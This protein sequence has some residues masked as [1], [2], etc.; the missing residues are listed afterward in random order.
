MVM[1]VHPTV[2]AASMIMTMM[3]RRTTLM[4]VMVTVAVILATTAASMVQQQQQQQPSPSQQSVFLNTLYRDARDTRIL[5]GPAEAQVLYERIL[6]EYN[7]TDM[8]TSTRLAAARRNERLLVNA[9]CDTT[10]TASSLQD[11]TEKLQ[12]LKR[13]LQSDSVQYTAAHISV[14]MNNHNNTSPN[15]MPRPWRAPISIVPATAGT[16]TCQEFPFDTT[17]QQFTA[18]QC[19]LSLFLLG[20]CVTIQDAIS[21]CSVHYVNLLKEL[22]LICHCEH[23][24]NVIYALV[25]ITPIDLP[26]VHQTLH[27]VTDWH[28]RVLNRIQMGSNTIGHYTPRNN[29]EVVMYIGPDSLALVEHAILNPVVTTNAGS[30]S[31]PSNL[32]SN[33]NTTT[34]NTALLDLCTGSGVQALAYLMVKMATS[35][36]SPHRAVCVDTNPRALRFCQFSA[37]LNGILP[38]MITLVLGNVVQ[39]IGRVYHHHPH[40]ASPQNDNNNERQQRPLLQLLQSVHPTY[41][42]ITANPPFLP[43]PTDATTHGTVAQRYGLFSSGGPSG[44]VV[45]AAVLSLSKSLANPRGGMTAI[46][47]EFF[48]RGNHLHRGGGIPELIERLQLYYGNVTQN[49][50]ADNNH[51]EGSTAILF[52]NEFPISRQV[53]ANRRADTF[54]EAQ[55]WYD[56]L[57]AENISL[58]SPGLLFVQ[59][60]VPPPHDSALGNTKWMHHHTVPK[61]DLGSIWTPSNHKAI[62]VTR[63][64]TR[65]VFGGE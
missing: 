60:N 56:H 9:C 18:G 2:Y 32:D 19:L 37:A 28:P 12:D 3:M 21:A 54:K 11:G 4:V 5:R 61:S 50:N 24:P 57:Q 59:K 31:A 51:T 45:L 30:H 35:P 17:Q 1:I 39:G 58:C 52:T 36:S 23:H 16:V 13:W 46:V 29:D 41:D 63:G 7:P 65:K 47:S 42:I 6:L 25:S 14:L 38:S 55:V 44:E 20:L 10:T 26:E 62:T 22:G 48:F 15:A 34:T 33:R 27:V 53:Y 40:G 8:T 43:V 49:E 64:K